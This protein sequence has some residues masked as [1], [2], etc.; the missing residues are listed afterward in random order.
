[1]TVTVYDVMTTV[2]TGGLLGILGQ[3]IRMTIGLKK[4]SDTNAN[5]LAS[6]VKEVNANRLLVSLFIGFV[7][8][9]L[10]LLINGVEK[11]GN[12]EFIFSVIA[13]GYSGTDFIE[14]LFNTYIS[15]MGNTPA[16][17][18]APSTTPTPVAANNPTD[19]SSFAS[20]ERDDEHST[21]L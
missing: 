7:A 3:G 13:A 21:N 15:K 12:R 16:T 10:F 19:T 8:G 2:I 11:I 20:H 5:K 9:S 1:M 14:G 18:A 6:E 17:V 4:L